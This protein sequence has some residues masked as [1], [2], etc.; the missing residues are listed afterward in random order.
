[1]TIADAIST[2]KD[3]HILG[4]WRSAAYP[5]E[6][7]YR[8]HPFNRDAKVSASVDYNG[9]RIRVGDIEESLDNPEDAEDFDSEAAMAW[10]DKRLREL[11]VLFLD[12][13]GNIA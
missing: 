3:A 9:S 2:L 10:A 4:P 8:A 13:Q 11:G 6:E 7:E 12:A 1:M 5:S